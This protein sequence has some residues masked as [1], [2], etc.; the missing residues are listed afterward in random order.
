M[1]GGTLGSYFTRAE[2][3]RDAA[4]VAVVL[5]AGLFPD[6]GRRFFNRIERYASKFATRKRAT[7]FAAA[8]FPVLFRVALLPW[9]PVPV[10]HIHDEFSYLLAGDTFAHGR[11]TNPPHPLRIF[12]DTIHVNQ[13]P[14]YMS[15]Y[16]PLQGA[17]LAAGEAMGNPWIGVLL[18]VAAMCAAGVW[19]LQGWLPPRWALLGGVLLA[20][21]LG[22]FSYW[23]NS[24]WGGAAAFTGGALVLGAVPRLVR[25]WRAADAVLLVLG[26]AILANSRPFEG[27]I[28][29]AT[30]MGYLLWRFVAR[31]KAGIGTPAL[32]LIVPAALLGVATLAF[33]GYYNW[34]GTGSALTFPY[35]VNDRTYF[36]TQPFPWSKVQ[37]ELQYANPQF[38][39]FYN[40]WER[41][42]MLMIHEHKALGILRQLGTVGIKTVY[43]YFW[44]EMCVALLALPFVFFDR[45]MRFLLASCL[46]SLAGLMIIVWFAPHYLAPVAPAMFAVLV[47]CFRHLRQLRLQSRLV[48][49][50]IS[51]AL[52]LFSLAIAPFHVAAGVYA[53]VPPNHQMVYRAA[54]ESRLRTTTGLH[55]VIVEY[56]PTHDESSEWVYN[57]A[58]IDRA[59]VVWARQI[60]GVSLQPLLDYFCGRRVWIAEPD[61]TP[62]RLIPMQ[63]NPAAACR[64]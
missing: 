19:M 17:A 62:P 28:L 3:I 53:A 59:K 49:A 10:P 22:V 51:R 54:F 41:Q 29:F 39:D 58:D 45:R 36:S 2:I 46:V 56:A 23:A 24:Y 1:L 32:R 13:L 14:T 31:R 43:F 26:G 20:L 38:E 52:I 34:R 61:A 25:R 55:L 60:P 35:T 12:F 42:Q 4:L 40:H 47:Q 37:P 27:A 11:L 5:L 33:M 21:R 15:K 8:L 9:L 18:S 63:S 50:A 64:Q 48:G 7:I 57:G 16:P 30:S 6:I 44:P